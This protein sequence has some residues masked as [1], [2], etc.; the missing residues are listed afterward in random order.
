MG[1]CS[2]LL[3]SS[4]PVRESLS[5]R[6]ISHNR[7]E[8]GKGSPNVTVREKDRLGNVDVQ[9]LESSAASVVDVQAVRRVTPKSLSISG[10][11]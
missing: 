3:I 1:K 7:L 2:D 9:L 4:V 5:E 8:N 10:S 6:V 11:G